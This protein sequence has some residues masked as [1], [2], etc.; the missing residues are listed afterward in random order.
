[1]SV[2]GSNTNG[3][4]RCVP[5]ASCTTGDAMPATTSAL[6]TTRSG[7]ATKPDPST[8]PPQPCPVIFTVDRPAASAAACTSADVGPVTGFVGAGSRS[9]NTC[10][11]PSGSSRRPSRAVISGAGGSTTSRRRMM[12]ESWI[13]GPCPAFGSVASVPARSHTT[14]STPKLD[15]IP[16]SAMSTRPR[17]MRR[18][19]RAARAPRAI[20]RARRTAMRTRPA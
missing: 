11:K 17:W 13:N 9:A 15:A 12:A 16:P 18:R 1:M 14:T 8:T 2:A 20:L 5:F 3:V 6:V 10:G 4:A 7:P 19:S